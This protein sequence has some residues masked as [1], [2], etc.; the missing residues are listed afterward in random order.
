MVAR[1]KSANLWD[2]AE[3]TPRPLRNIFFQMEEMMI[4]S[5]KAEMG[6]RRKIENQRKNV[7]STS[8]PGEKERPDDIQCFLSMRAAAKRSM[9]L[10]KLSSP[11]C[12]HRKRGRKA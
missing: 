4:L 5:K 11:L 6:K 7:K 12:S 9:I 8:V 10:N 2:A 3:R 1:S